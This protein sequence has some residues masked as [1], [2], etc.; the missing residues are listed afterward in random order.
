MYIGLCRVPEALGKEAE[1]GSV[2]VPSVAV[3]LVGASGKQGG[4]LVRSLIPICF[5][6][7]CF[8]LLLLQICPSSITDRWILC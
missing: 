1:S 6:F 5:A 2:G 8:I 3:N 7:S 4:Q